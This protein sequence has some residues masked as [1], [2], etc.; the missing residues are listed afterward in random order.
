MKKISFLPFLGIIAVV[1]IT[2][3]CLTACFGSN[4]TDRNNGDTTKET[5]DD[6]AELEAESTVSMTNYDGTEKRVEINIRKNAK[7][8]TTIKP[9]ENHADLSTEYSN[10]VNAGIATV[11]IK[12][13]SGSKKFKGETQVSFTILRITAETSD[14]SNLKDYLSSGNY[15][16]VKLSA[17]TEIPENETLVIEK[18]TFLTLNGYDLVS[19]GKIENNGTITTSGDNNGK[20]GSII[21]NGETVQ[22][23]KIFLSDGTKLLN[24]GKFTNDGEINVLGSHAEIYTDS[25]I[26]GNG[27]VGD[28][29]AVNVRVP[30]T[31]ANILLSFDRA[32]YTGKELKPSVTVVANGKSV[33]GYEYDVVYSDNVNAGT[34]EITL[35]AKEDSKNVTGETAVT[36]I[37]DKAEII[38]D[39]ETDFL[40]A[41]ANDNY[42]SVFAN[43]G[44]ITQNFTVPE[45]L[46]VSVNGLIQC[47]VTV[48][49]TLVAES[50]DSYSGVAA[51]ARFKGKIINNG[52]VAVNGSAIIENELSGGGEYVNN[53]KIFFE[54]TAVIADG[55]TVI[56]KNKAFSNTSVS[57]LQNAENGT[58]TL[59]E[60]LTSDLVRLSETEFVYDGQPKTPYCI[61]DLHEFNAVTYVYQYR[62]EGASENNSFPKNAG[63]VLVRVA[64]NEVSETYFGEVTLQ[65]EIKPAAISVGTAKEFYEAYKS[66]NYYEITADFRLTFDAP[67]TVKDGV[68]IVVPQGQRLVANAILTINGKLTNNGSYA[69][70]KGRAIIANGG[71]FINNGEAFFNGSAPDGITG[72]GA[73]Y[74]RIDIKQAVWIDFPTEVVYGVYGAANEPE[75]KLETP[76]GTQLMR[77][78]G[79]D[80]ALTYAN[81]NGVSVNGNQASVTVTADTFSKFVYGETKKE[82]EVTEGTIEVSTFDDFLKAVN[83]VVSGTDVCNYKEIHF[84]SNMEAKNDTALDITVEIRPNTTVFVGGFDAYFTKGDRYNREYKIVNNGTIKANADNAKWYHGDASFSGK[85]TETIANS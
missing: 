18:D 51:A 15:S 4:N 78:A 52:A 57:G 6:L 61:F 35:S 38:V 25:E 69:D 73:V 85:P 36:F 47:N 50:N 70:G 45:N 28:G 23:G 22:S 29:I 67:F 24:K 2:S 11:K 33:P 14:F 20:R 34:A 27:S 83:N 79:K 82:Y 44:T 68:E 13:K 60:Q 75:V 76:D 58:F 71:K 54:P 77:G 65:Y 9:D 12:A 31:E 30:L 55:T 16:N 66:G 8:V 53:G 10:N 26:T 74:E 7:I 5:I 43:I 59:R 39:N 3:V 17:N 41:L 48:N 80:F 72:E 42:C 40:S 21:L 46:S 81:A 56:N 19:Y 37:I 32:D 64:F 1:I 63:K 62:Y 49:G 84:T